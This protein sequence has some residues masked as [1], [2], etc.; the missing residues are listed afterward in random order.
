M[1]SIR[2][3]LQW[4][5]GQRLSLKAATFTSVKAVTFA[6][7][8]WFALRAEVERYGP[9]SRAAESTWDHPF[10]GVRNVL[11][12]IYTGWWSLFRR[13]AKQHLIDPQSLVP[14]SVMPG[15][16]WL[17]TNEVDGVKV[18]QNALI[19]RSLWGSLH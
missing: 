19:P 11:V 6:T 18:S 10:F 15:F 16:P 9:Y 12:L 13:L 2:R 8:K 14:E 5:L 4:S 17:A 3:F 1:A 7:R